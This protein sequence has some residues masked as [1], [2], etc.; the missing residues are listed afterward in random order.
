L[1]LRTDIRPDQSPANSYLDDID[2]TEAAAEH[3]HEAIGIRNDRGTC[4]GPG[5]TL[6]LAAPKASQKMIGERKNG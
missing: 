3:I 5:L 2:R 1:A 6:L 4:F